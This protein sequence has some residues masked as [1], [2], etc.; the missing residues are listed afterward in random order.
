VASSKDR[1]RKLARAKIDRQNARRAIR[2]RRK[3]RVYAGV[4]AGLAVLLILAG[5]AW[6]GGFFDRDE[7][8]P[9]EAQDTC[10]WTPQSAES[11]TQLKD[12]GTPPTKDLP[13]SGTAPMTIT[14]GQGAMTVAL[15]LVTA[16]CA[17]ASFSFLAGKKFFDGTECTE[18]TTEGALHCGDPGGTGQGGPTY[19]FYD[20]NV[21]QA[22][23]PEPSASAAPTGTVLY[24]KGTVAM[25][26]SPPGTNGSQFL[27]FLKDFTPKDAPAYSIVGRVSS[28]E[29]TLSKLALI[30]TVNNADGV[31]VKPKDK[32]TI[33]TLTVGAAAPLGAPD[34]AAS[35]QS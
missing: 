9:A 32:I 31:K 3:R 5:V 20:E 4:G 25:I 12:V 30:P 17:G 21:P 33:Q 22:P 26:G 35:S 24:P 6:L 27:V 1:Q 14:T 8:T 11:N 16:P 18:I 10:L 19:S 15:D 29:D 23:Q 34:P 28:G 2:E 7:D 13:T